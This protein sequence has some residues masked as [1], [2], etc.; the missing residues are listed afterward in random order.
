[1]NDGWTSS[2]AER[3]TFDNLIEGKFDGARAAATDVLLH[4]VLEVAE[5]VG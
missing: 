4:A 3:A 2:A 5:V 1:L